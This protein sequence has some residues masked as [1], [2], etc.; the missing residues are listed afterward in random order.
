M[1]KS[2]DNVDYEIGISVDSDSNT[3][4]WCQTIVTEGDPV[5]KYRCNLP[6]YN[7]VT[8]KKFESDTA[9]LSFLENT[10]RGYWDNWYDDPVE[11]EE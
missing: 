6:A 8:F 3:V 4:A 7:P 2:I 11:E 9:R 5:K 10:P 1:L